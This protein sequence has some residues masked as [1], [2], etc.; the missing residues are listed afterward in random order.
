[1]T[2]YCPGV[3]VPLM[4][5]EVES[6]IPGRGRVYITP[7][8]DISGLGSKPASEHLIGCI[9][10]RQRVYINPPSMLQVGRSGTRVT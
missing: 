7:P 8:G 4:E 5:I 10:S 6:L 2:R 9:L 1:M 3:L